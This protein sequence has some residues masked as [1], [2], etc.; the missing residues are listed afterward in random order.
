MK[1]KCGNRCRLPAWL[2]ALL[3]PC[4]DGVTRAGREGGEGLVS[5]GVCEALGSM[6]LGVPYAVQPATRHGRACGCDKS[7]CA[8]FV[9][10][11]V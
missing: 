5:C 2:E 10:E 1:L 4:W 11:C 3:C 9:L 7:K 6:G 8:D